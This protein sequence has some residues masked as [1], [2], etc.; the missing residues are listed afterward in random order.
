M[1]TTEDPF[2]G[3][4]IQFPALHRYPPVSLPLRHAKV[5]KNGMPMG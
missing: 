5:Y 2:P 1:M 4:Q 3:M